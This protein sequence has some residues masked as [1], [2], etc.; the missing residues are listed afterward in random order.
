M[1]TTNYLVSDSGLTLILASPS[2]F[3]DAGLVIC[4]HIKL[5]AVF[6]VTSDIVG[7]YDSPSVDF[8]GSDNGSLY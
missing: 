8:D 6:S 1:P 7:I 5:S 2:G 4:V 3:R